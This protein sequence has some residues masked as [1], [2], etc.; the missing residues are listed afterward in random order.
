MI[1]RGL[2]VVTARVYVD[3]VRPFRAGRARLDGLGLDRGG[4]GASHVTGFVV[5]RCPAQSRAAAKHTV[6]ALRSLLVYLH[7]EGEIGRP[8]TAAAPS[9]A[10]WRR[11]RA[12]PA[13][14]RGHRAAAGRRV[15]AGDR[16]VVAPSLCGDDGDLR[17]GRPRVASRNRPRVA[18]RTSMSP[19]RRANPLTT[20]TMRRALG[21]TLEREGMLL[22]QFV[23]FVEER[24]EQRLTI[25]AAW[26]GRRCRRP[27]RRGGQA[28]CEWSAVLPPTCTRSIPRPRFPRR[29]CCARRRIV[30]RRSSTAS[31]RSRP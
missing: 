12:P 9:V 30:R 8:L 16:S 2:N 17:Q 18:R 31:R 1:E 15:V 21:F 4:L 29:I 7:V 26:L 27:A 6:T 22:P 23:D 3:A 11:W 10:G 24:G 13:A 14:H 28:D 5:A 20:S 19:L 25:A